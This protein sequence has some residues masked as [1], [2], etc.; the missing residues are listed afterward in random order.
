MKR[1]PFV[2]MTF[3]EERA[4]QQDINVNVRMNEDWQQDLKEFKAIAGIE[5][6]STALKAALIIAKNVLH[7]Q[8]SDKIKAQLALDRQ[9]KSKESKSQ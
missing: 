2:P 6:D 7:S 8:F 3:K 1:Q 9:P 4:R 5:S